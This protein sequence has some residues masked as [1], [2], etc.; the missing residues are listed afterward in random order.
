MKTENSKLEN[1]LQKLIEL[2][3]KELEHVYFKKGSFLNPTVIQLSQQLDE[4]IVI[5]Q[6]LRR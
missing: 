2:L 6:K 3:R 5:F 1:E 4:Y